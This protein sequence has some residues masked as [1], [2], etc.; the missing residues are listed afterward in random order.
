MGFFRPNAGIDLNSLRQQINLVCLGRIKP[1]S[2]N[3][4]PATGNGDIRNP[5][6]GIINRAAR[7]QHG[8]GRIQESAAIDGNPIRIGHDDPGPVPGNFQESVHRC[9]S[10][11]RHFIDNKFSRSPD[12]IRIGLNISRQPRIRYFMGIIQ[13]SPF[14][15]DVKMGIQIARHTACG[16]SRN[17]YQGN[18]IR[19]LLYEW[20]LGCRGFRIR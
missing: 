15:R 9:S 5:A 8:P 13:D 16:R 17:L 19:C 1:L 4:N 20:L 11:S 3:L 6:T 12:H 10:R 2:C 18:P 7:R 14:L